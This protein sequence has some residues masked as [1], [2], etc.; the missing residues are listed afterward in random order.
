M[1]KLTTSKI[2]RKEGSTSFKKDGTSTKQISV[3]LDLNEYYFIINKPP[4]GL[5][6]GL[7]EFIR[8]KIQEEQ[9]KR[10][11][12]TSSQDTMASAIRSAYMKGKFYNDV[13]DRLV[14][15]MTDW[16]DD[17]AMTIRHIGLALDQLQNL[18]R[19]DEGLPPFT[20]PDWNQ[21]LNTVTAQDTMSWFAIKDDPIRRDAKNSIDLL[22]VILKFFT[23]AN[24]NIAETRQ[25]LKDFRNRTQLSKMD[26]YKPTETGEQLLDTLLRPREDPNKFQGWE[27]D[28][29]TT[30]PWEEQK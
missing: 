10:G 17:Q 27:D 19:M 14:V 25:F 21:I 18:S 3:K 26:T 12:S 9:K 6:M 29:L 2:I 30:A 16:Y 22:K 1:K 20:L 23:R 8:G 15:A 4:A 24:P 7:T 28:Q 13:Y 5:G 11:F